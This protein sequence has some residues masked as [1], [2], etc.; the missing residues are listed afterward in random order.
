[1][2]RL[3]APPIDVAVPANSPAAANATPILVAPPPAAVPGGGWGL[4]AASPP[5]AP[6]PAPARP[7]A[8]PLPALTPVI[9]PHPGPFR[10]QQRRSLAEMANEQL[11][12]GTKPRDPFAEGMGEA[13]V[14]DCLHGPTN[15]PTVAGLLAAPGLAARAL[16]GRCAK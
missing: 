16:S 1:V 14:D 3:Q 8:P 9:P 15:T 5:A 7:S 10:I 2:Q 6:S 12:R 13:S 11:R 4:P